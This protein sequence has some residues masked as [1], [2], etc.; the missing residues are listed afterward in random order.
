MKTDNSNKLSQQYVSVKFTLKNPQENPEKRKKSSNPGK[1]VEIS[2]VSLPVLLK[3][4]KNVLEK[5]KFFKERN[6]IT[7]KNINT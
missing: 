1:R 6:K 4:S 3:P 2:R 7:I 5:S